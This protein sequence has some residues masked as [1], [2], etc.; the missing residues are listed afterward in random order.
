MPAGQT[1]EQERNESRAAAFVFGVSGHRDLVA[2]DVPELQRQLD[3]VFASFCAAYPD[4]TYEL[5]SPLAEGADRLAAKVAL[6]RGIRLLV[7]MPMAQPEYERD[8]ATGGSLDEF[9][10]MVAAASTSWELGSA[11]GIDASKLPA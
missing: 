1:T 2:A 7:P 3:R 6:A 5:L 9:R 4:R 10:R 11:P 8:F